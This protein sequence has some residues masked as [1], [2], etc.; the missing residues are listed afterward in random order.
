MPGAGVDGHT[1]R[2][3]DFTFARTRLDRSDLTSR[4]V[5][6]GFRVVTGKFEHGKRWNPA[7]EL[8]MTR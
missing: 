7:V 2:C 3:R 8:A 4:L 1:D 5:P 6:A